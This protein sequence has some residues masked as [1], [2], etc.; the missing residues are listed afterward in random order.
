MDGIFALSRRDFLKTGAVVGGGLVLGIS[1][2]GPGTPG[3]ALA[4]APEPT[5][6]NAFIQVA[7]DGTVTMIL[8]K[9]EMGQG[10]YTALPMLLAEE[11]ECDWKKIRVESAPVAPIYNHTGF[12]TQLTG[13]STSVASEWERMRKVGAAARE[14]LIAAAARRW[15]V[16]RASCRAENGTVVH[17]SGRKLTFGQLAEEASKMTVPEQ[18]PLK[19]PSAFRIIGKPTLRLDTLEKVTGKAL[20]GLDADV[21]G[22]L[23][24]LVARPPVFGGRMKSFNAAEARAVPGVR[25][26]VRLETGVAI[27]A[28]NFWSAKQ[29][30][31]ALEVVWAEGPLAGLSTSGL[32]QEYRT[33]AG[34]PGA[35]A[36]KEGDAEKALQA[37]AKRID[38]EYEVPYLAHATMEPLN[39]LVDV[40]PGRCEI[41]TGTQTQTWERDA[42]AR[43]TGLKPERVQVHTTLLGGGFGRRANPHSDYVSE[44]VSVAKAIGKPVKTVWTREDDMQ[45][46][47]Y[48][49][50]WYDRLSA[51]LDGKGNLTAWQHTIVGQ[52]I[53]AGTAPRRRRTAA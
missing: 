17:A 39:C 35:I 20:F 13:G 24:A 40:R 52:S 16:D 32:R 45:G 42:A 29:A 27:V 50:M 38:A 15:G 31:D 33:L 26:V 48:R 46:G 11:L 53:M 34:T 9:A 37:A 1:L 3:R 36:R 8:N 47:Y 5:A 49:P 21:P 4:Q 6:L 7:P 14:M 18:I 28:D 30:R 51:G 10:V 19:D 44:A 23:T 22:A 25:A 12:G 41:W 2:P 43:I